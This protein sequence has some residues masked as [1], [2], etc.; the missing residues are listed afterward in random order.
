MVSPSNEIRWKQLDPSSDSC[1]W[2][3]CRQEGVVRYVSGATPL[4]RK[5]SIVLCERHELELLGL[6]LHEP[7]RSKRTVTPDDK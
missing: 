7:Q 1:C 3:K 2:P 6:T 5:L 4:N